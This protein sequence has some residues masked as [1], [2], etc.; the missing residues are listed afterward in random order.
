MDCDGMFFEKAYRIQGKDALNFVSHTHP[1][2]LEIIQT[3]SGGGQVLIRDTLYPMVAGGLY[4]INAAEVH[5]TNP[6]DPAR[7]LRSK[8]IM[9]AEG[10]TRVARDLGLEKQF[11]LLFF[12]AGGRYV[13]LEEQQVWAV[14]ALLRNVCA[15]D[16]DAGDDP[17]QMWRDLMQ[18]L[19][20]SMSGAAA[21]R[22]ADGAI[23]AVMACINNRIGER[24]S[25]QAISDELHMDKYYL[26]HYFKR[27]TSMT[28]MEY[29]TERRVNM[30]MR[31]LSNTNRSV[32]ETAQLCGFSSASYFNQV[33]RRK[34]GKTPSEYR[35]G[36]SSQQR[37]RQDRID[38][39][40][41]LLGYRAEAPALRLKADG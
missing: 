4:L 37:E 12:T 40:T 1:G 25:L 9:S 3:L 2:S 41:N 33:F 22:A 21:S 18:L 27:K 29:I 31:M 30:A 36:V 34:T 38:G 6:T 11:E 28:I 7:Y 5:C 39:N 16:A 26:C 24:I 10:M 23:D 17:F 20:L 35:A 13:A 8:L 32:T 19:S 15:F 14:D